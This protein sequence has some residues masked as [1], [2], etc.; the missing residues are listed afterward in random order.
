[1]TPISERAKLILGGRVRIA[2]SFEFVAARTIESALLRNVLQPVVEYSYHRPAS[3]LPTI[4]CPHLRAATLSCHPLL[5]LHHHQA[6][7]AADPKAN[8]PSHQDASRA[9]LL[10]SRHVHPQTQSPT[11][12]SRTSQK[13]PSTKSSSMAS[14][15][16]LNSRHHERSKRYSPLPRARLFNHLTLR[17]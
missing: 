1:M 16:S 6:G 12:D 4:C 5:S 11:R 9:S 15:T 3:C 17:H 10:P 2:S 7:R 8:H 14:T 13:T